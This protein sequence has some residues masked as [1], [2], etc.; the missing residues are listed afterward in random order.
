METH[1]LKLTNFLGLQTQTQWISRPI[2]A[3]T[4][5]FSFLRLH[6]FSFAAAKTF[7]SRS[8]TMNR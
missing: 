5:Q 7:L 3:S 2:A 1:G 6:P 4:V 8:S